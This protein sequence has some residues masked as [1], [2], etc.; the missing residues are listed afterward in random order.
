[1]RA[2]AV[3]LFGEKA[4]PSVT[5]HH[6]E[7]HGALGGRLDTTRLMPTPAL[8]EISAL[9]CENS[10][11]PWLWLVCTIRR[12]STVTTG[13]SAPAPAHKFLQFFSSLF[14]RPRVVHHPLR[15]N[16]CPILVSGRAQCAIQLSQCCTGPRLSVPR[17]L[18]C[19]S[20]HPLRTTPMAEPV[21]S[22]L[23]GSPDRPPT[24]SRY[25]FSYPRLVRRLMSC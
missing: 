4:L 17:T 8:A 20:P 2:P 3:D 24:Y 11:V 12:H 5:E 1:M 19:L 13:R 6:L 10:A 22:I 18:S 9:P 14:P 16:T 15:S 23:T 7:A 25:A 21:W